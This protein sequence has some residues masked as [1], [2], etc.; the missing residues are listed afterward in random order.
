MNKIFYPRLS[1]ETLI[2]KE[3]E[4]FDR[5]SQTP[6][7]SKKLT[8]ESI[9][10]NLIYGILFNGFWGF[11][12]TFYSNSDN[13]SLNNYFIWLRIIGILN[14]IFSFIS[15]FIIPGL[16][17]FIKKK[18]ENFSL[19]S[20][21]GTIDNSLKF[22]LSL[23]KILRI[24]CIIIFFFCYGIAFGIYSDK[25]KEISN[26]IFFY[27]VICSILVGIFIVIAILQLYINYAKN[28]KSQELK[29]KYFQ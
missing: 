10:L 11:F 23:L 18:M 13:C 20:Y 25:C 16:L 27:I 19:Y 7:I 14:L 5:L 3:D 4:N 1:S 17:L 12:F 8:N 2:K 22:A 26:L 21:Y 29:S 24:I 28:I 6:E 15:I 9:F